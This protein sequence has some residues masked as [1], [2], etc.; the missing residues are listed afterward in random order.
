V[1]SFSLS[2]FFR[3][4]GEA[5][6]QALRDLFRQP[7]TS[8]L[9]IMA[10]G[11]AL[12]LPGML[13]S[14]LENSHK[15][16]DPWKDGRE[17]NVFMK[18]EVSDDR[19]AELANE[20]REDGE[21]AE[22]EPITREQALTQFKTQSGLADAL[23]LLEENPLP[24]VLIIHPADSLA[25]PAAVESLGK[26]LSAEADVDAVQIDQD[27]IQR[28]N[29][30][31]TFLRIT[32]W[33]L[34][35]LFSLMVF[36]VINNSLRFEIIRRRNEV[37]VIKLIGGSHIFIQRPFLYT[38]LLLGLFG[39]V[40]AIIFIQLIFAFLAPHMEALLQHYSNTTSPLYLGTKTALL[41]PVATLVVS[42]LSTLIAIR[43]NLREI[44]P[45]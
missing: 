31:F 45:Q 18:L 11:L 39:A 38:A 23:D 8:I 10:I 14:I 24:A 16:M 35:L 44:E 26:R 19:L 6:R 28:L 5:G 40:V 12:A 30:F 7:L 9:T 43:I 3:Q 17:I 37:E 20:W 1:N 32:T 36:L 2:D 33:V 42:V 22:V 15:T 13:L 27:W 4:H 29:D 25:T 41:I 34:A 21:I